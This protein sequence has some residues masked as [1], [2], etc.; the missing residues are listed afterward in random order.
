M[1]QGRPLGYLVCWLRGSW[2]HLSKEAHRNARYSKQ[3]REEGRA[4]LATLENGPLLLAWERD[5]RAGEGVEPGD[6]P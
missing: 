6:H 1:A 4:Y 3:E 5:R 2:G